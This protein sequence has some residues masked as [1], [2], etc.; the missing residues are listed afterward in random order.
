MFIN[1]CI[2][3]Y[4]SQKFHLFFLFICLFIHF[5]VFVS[6]NLFIYSDFYLLLHAHPEQ[7]ILKL[8]N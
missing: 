3:V 1:N 6:T 4:M 8:F 7:L 2:V 5:L